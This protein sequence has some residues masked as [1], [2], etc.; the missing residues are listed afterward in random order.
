MG[1]E[2]RFRAAAVRYVSVRPG[3]NRTKSAPINGLLRTI[4]LDPV[5]AITWRFADCLHRKV[6]HE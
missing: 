5:N 1:F 6:N 3:A 4:W 2:S